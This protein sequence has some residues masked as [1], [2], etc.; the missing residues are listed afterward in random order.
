MENREP[1][2]A[3]LQELARR[4]FDPTEEEWLEDAGHRLMETLV[5]QT[6]EYS[7]ERWINFYAEQDNYFPPY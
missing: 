4:L 3:Q 6:D 2:P 5:T 1:T 7:R